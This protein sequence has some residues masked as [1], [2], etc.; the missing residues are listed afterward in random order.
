M[1]GGIEATIRVLKQSSSESADNLLLAAL[2]SPERAIQEGAVLALLGRRHSRGPVELVANWSRLKPRWR[3]LLMKHTAA[4]TDAVKLA[5]ASDDPA[6]LRNGCDAALALR[7]YESIPTLVDAVQDLERPERSPMLQTLLALVELLSEDMIG[8]RDYQSQRDPQTLRKQA[9]ASLEAA[10]ETFEQHRSPELIEAFL[11]LVPREHSGFRKLL[12]SPTG[13]VHGAL[14]ERMTVSPRPGVMRL[15]L[16]M[17]DDPQPPRAAMSVI[18]RRRDIQFLRQLLR[19]I[20]GDI[21]PVT[22]GN[23]K[24]LGKTVWLEDDREFFSPLSEKEQSACVRLA[25]A[26][27]AGRNEIL[28]LLKRFLLRGKPNG[29]AAA[30]LALAQFKGQD[31][32]ALVLECLED[33]EPEVRANLLPQLRSRGIPGAIDR[34]IEELDHPSEMVRNAC[35]NSL[36]D[37]SFA[38]YAASFDKL[39]QITQ[40]T[41]GKMILK[42]DSQTIP[43]LKEEMASEVRSRRRRAIEMA[44]AMGCVEPMQATLLNMLSDTDHFIRMSAINALGACDNEATRAALQQ[45]L[46]DSHP[47]VR[48]S[49]ASALQTLDVGRGIGAGQINMIEPLP[50]DGL[51]M[52]ADEVP[53]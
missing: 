39:S 11:M 29:R 24:R 35:R 9:V 6:R 8:P 4:C 20:S 47:A 13:R 42:I 16:S 1:T 46:R 19:K 23:L 31:V 34:L 28:A 43:M 53:A 33:P 22:Q 25:L 5:I 44:T 7:C 12:Q 27:H 45:A 14:I 49:A 26:L 2:R 52:A 50:I 32:N 17:L 38:R 3:T 41:E 30:A 21:D 37:F 48:E 10:M 15:V 40:I 18:E 36:S 51:E